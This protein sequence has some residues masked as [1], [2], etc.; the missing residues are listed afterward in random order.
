[1]MTII[2]ERDSM[3][4]QCSKVFEKEFGF[5]I[6]AS[7]CNLNPKL[8]PPAL[9][10]CL[11]ERKVTVPNISEMAVALLEMGLHKNLSPHFMEIVV[12]IFQLLPRPCF[13]SMYYLRRLHYGKALF[14]LQNNSFY[15]PKPDPNSWQ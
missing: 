7:F 11:T 14:Y 2:T 15:G 6:M 9:W 8:W 3:D 1:M 4:K 5:L 13:S 10:F 12:E